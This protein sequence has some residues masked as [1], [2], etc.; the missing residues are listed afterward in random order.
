MLTR[1]IIALCAL[2]LPLN[3]QAQSLAGSWDL[4]IDDTTVFR[5]AI[6]EG[7]D[8][9]W[10]GQW[11]RPERFNSDG[12]AFYNMRGGVKSTSSMTGILFRDM[13]E[14]AFEDPRPGAIPD[15]FRFR[16]TGPNSAEMT[17]VGTGLA[18]YPLVRAAP[19][20]TIGNWDATR[21]YRR[22]VGAA[23]AQPA[24][25]E[26]EPAPAPEAESIEPPAA[27]ERASRIGRDFLDGL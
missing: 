10:L 20:G 1:L 7:Q 12:N 16:L 25:A 8:G 21:V 5:F 14:L 22:V 11:H 15:I 3:V 4:R 27:P 13:V 23:A 26:P 2:L 9:E 6:A 24:P 18:P 19:G 17:Y